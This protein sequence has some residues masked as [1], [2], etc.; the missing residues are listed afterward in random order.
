M[1]HRLKPIA[2]SAWTWIISAKL[3]KQ[4]LSPVHHAVTAF[5]LSFRRETITAL[6]RYLKTSVGRGGSCS[7]AWHT[8][9]K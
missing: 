1:Q 9:E 6:A 8:S 3:F 2:R 7:Y 4:L 5:D